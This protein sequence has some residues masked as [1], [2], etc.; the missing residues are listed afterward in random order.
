[1]GC[2]NY[3]ASLPCLAPCR[4]RDMILSIVVAAVGAV[5]ESGAK[6]GS[7]VNANAL[8]NCSLKASK[9]PAHE[10]T[11]GQRRYKNVA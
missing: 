11:G 3:S 10:H 2:H 6:R 9:S 5:G 7:L 4:V 8:G 1:M